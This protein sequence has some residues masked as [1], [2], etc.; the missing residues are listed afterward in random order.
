MSQEQGA[1]AGGHI[2]AKCGAS[3]ETKEEL[4]RHI[5]SEHDGGDEAE[6]TKTGT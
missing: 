1:P 2:C 4:D 6:E 3:F 5:A